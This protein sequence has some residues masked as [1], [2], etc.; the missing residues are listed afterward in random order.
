VRNDTASFTA[1][2]V[3]AMRGL[4]AFLPERLRLV[5]DP[6]G[7]RF[8]RGLGA[9]FALPGVARRAGAAAPIWMRGYLRR[10]AIYMQLRTRVIDDDVAAF[11]RAG[12][13][14][15]VLLGAGFDCRAWRLAALTGA[16][17]YEV[18]HPAT[19]KTKR[20]IMESE[21]SK[22]RVVFVPWDF[23]HEPLSA[24]PERLKREGHDASA[25]TMTILEGVVMYLTAPA[26]DATLGCIAR[27]SSPHSPLA[28]TYMESD[29][30]RP[31]AARW[32]SGRALVRFVGEPFR[33][34]FEPARF[35]DWLSAR[36]FHLERDESAAEA[37]V[38]LLRLD[39]KRAK[40]LRKT[41]SHFALARRTDR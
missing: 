33:S 37:G 6:Y 5:D 11:V 40:R 26:L 1:R 32:A 17:V 14:Q 30:M 13:R 21:A 25:P 3:A 35:A 34:G 15:L 16:T 7:L 27:Y 31:L 36:G 19:Q 2:W 8:A 18:D 20:E 23:E 29:L 12:G 28:V 10:F 4:G 22:G 39:A 41:L 38:R 9:L 24:L